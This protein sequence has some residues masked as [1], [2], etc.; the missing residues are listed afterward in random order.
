[1]R[2]CTGAVALLV[3]TLT[4]HEHPRRLTTRDRAADEVDP[5]RLHERR[6]IGGHRQAPHERRGVLDVGAGEQDVTHVDVGRARL[7]VEVVAVVPPRHETE[8]T[9]R[10]VGGGAGPDD[11]LHV[12]AEHL[13]PGG[14]ARL[15]SLVGGEPH[16]LVGPEHLG[17]GGVHPGDVALVRDDDDAPPVG[18]Q[19]STS[20]LGEGHRPVGPGRA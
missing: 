11:H 14:V 7:E 10:G 2:P 19:G 5:A 15:R 13:E 8:V 18:G 17:Q 20:S 3:G 6:D 4:R 12:S 16:V 9:D 1:M